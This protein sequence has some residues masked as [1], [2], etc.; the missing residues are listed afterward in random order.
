MATNLRPDIALAQRLFDALREKTFDGVGVTREAYGRGEE[1]A[2][3]LVRAEAEKLGLEI[4]VDFAGNMYM[5]LPGTDRSLPRIM[6]GSH[7]DSVP[8]GGN[9]DGAAGVLCGMAVV[10]GM[11]QAAFTPTRDVTV[12]AIR[13]EEGGAWFNGF[14][15]SR[16]ALGSF[17][18]ENL[19][20]LRPDT[21]LSLEHHIRELGFDPDALRE[22]RRYIEP[23]TVAAYVE[24]HIEQGPVLDAEEIPMGLVTA[25]PGN[26]RV[27]RGMVRGEWNH[28][29]A[30][31]RAY[32]HDAALALAEFAHRLDLFWASVEAEGVPLVITFCTIET[33]DQAGFGKVPGEISFSLDVRAPEIATLDRAY[34]E[35]DRLTAAISAARGVSFAL[36]GRQAS[37]PTPMDA[38]LREALRQSAEA[39][40]I[41]HK[42]M[43]SGGGHD[44]A[45]FAQAGIPAAM[46]FVR[47]QNGSHT[48]LED[49]RMEDFAA[50]TAAITHWCAKAAAA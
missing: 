13:A 16:G 35:I 39:M 45:A 34:A 10:A 20:I 49:M 7:L 42:I 33:S 15:G 29:G 32:R 38:T 14:P 27:R 18:P 12:M 41:P 17:P 3:A 50:A 36:E 22:G 5:T 37:V 28:S 6:L 2:H 11:R 4:S 1:I 9:Y 48:P 26:R 21:G 23:E 8:Q 30:T 25:L 24:L 43:P 46:V 47:N 19:S 44:A 40:G 31:P